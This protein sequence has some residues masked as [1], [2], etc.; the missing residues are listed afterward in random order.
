MTA[1]TTQT[2]YPQASGQGCDLYKEC[3]P[4]VGSRCSQGCCTRR[5]TR[6]VWL[7]LAVQLLLLRW[8]KGTRQGGTR[9]HMPCPTTTASTITLSP[10]TIMIALPTAVD[11]AT[12]GYPITRP[13]PRNPFQARGAL[14]CC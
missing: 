12:S 5:N 2:V 13:A 6:T 9:G 1:L 4:S 8:C 7:K 11:G 14:Q 10:T 3:S